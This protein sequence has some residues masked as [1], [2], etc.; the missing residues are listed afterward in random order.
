VPLFGHSTLTNSAVIFIGFVKKPLKI[1]AEERC[2]VKAG[3]L[4][5]FRED[6]GLLVASIVLF[7]VAMVVLFFIAV[8]TSG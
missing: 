5:K 4:R 7:K 6:G 2:E 8:F 3:R 1:T